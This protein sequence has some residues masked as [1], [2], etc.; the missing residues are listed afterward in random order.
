MALSG[1]AFQHQQQ[2]LLKL[3]ETVRLVIIS[4]SSKN[5]QRDKFFPQLGEY[6]PYE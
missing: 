1:K 6:R 2:M 3:W 4:V 5:L